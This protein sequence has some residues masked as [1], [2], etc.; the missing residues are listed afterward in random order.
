M[1][2]KFWNNSNIVSK[3]LFFYDYLVNDLNCSFAWKCNQKHILS[4]Y[5]NITDRHMEIGPGT[6]YFLKN[7]TFDTIQL[8]DINNDILTNA[9]QNLTGNCSQINTFQHDIFTSS[10]PQLSKCNS[11]G[12]TYVLHCI[13]DKIENNLDNLIHNIP[14]KNYNIYGASVI[15]DPVEKNMLAELELFWLNKMGI[16]NNDSDTYYGLCE[17]LENTG[18]NYN[19][20]LEGYVAIFNIKV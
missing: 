6:G 7:K 20:K 12:L 15:R 11:I 4:N 9:S 17:F 3:N 8:I 19:L 16:F 14:F 1:F 13:P 5:S 10:L 18:F 2:R